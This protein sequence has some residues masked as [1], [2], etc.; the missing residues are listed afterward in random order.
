M[1]KM[2]VGV[3]LLTLATAASS[4]GQSSGSGSYGL[5]SNSCAYFG[6]EYGRNPQVTEL[7]YFLWAQGFISGMNLSALAN[8][9][10]WRDLTGS[11]P[12]AI[13]R[14]IRAFC[15]ANPL[16]TFGAAALDA[17]GKLPARR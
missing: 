12:E 5:G 2:G 11:D 10:V 8:H 4:F 9:L 3:L 15:N 14:S 17:Y 6:Q 13:K 1:W 7:G 16:A